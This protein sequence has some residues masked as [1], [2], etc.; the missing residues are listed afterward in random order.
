MTNKELA[1]KCKKAMSEIES[2]DD[3]DNKAKWQYFSDAFDGNDIY[4][5][6]ELAYHWSNDLEEWCNE[7]LNE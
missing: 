2:A 1:T 7:M 3:F 5:V 6:F 4:R